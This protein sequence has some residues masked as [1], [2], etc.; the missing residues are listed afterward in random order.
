MLSETINDQIKNID[1]ECTI[2]QFD[3][4]YRTTRLLTY[5]ARENHPIG[6]FSWG[7]KIYLIYFNEFFF[8]GNKKSLR[9]LIENTNSTTI[10][11]QFV[12]DRYC[13]PEGM[14]LVMISNGKII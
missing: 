1:D 7:K 9:E 8:E 5:L 6:Q 4:H 11:K 13:I 12:S 14:N 10:L 3:D 2:A